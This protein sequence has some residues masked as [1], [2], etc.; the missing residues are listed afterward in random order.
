MDLTPVGHTALGRSQFL[1]HGD[2][3]RHDASQGCIILP[4]DIRDQI[5]NSRDNQ[6]N[7]VE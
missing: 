5:S 4:R 2:N 6:I 1:I 7:V 3:V